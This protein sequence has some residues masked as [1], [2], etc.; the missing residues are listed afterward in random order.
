VKVH[1]FRSNPNLL[2]GETHVNVEVTKFSGTPQE[3]TERYTVILRKHNEEAE[4][5]R[6]EF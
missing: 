5:C 6:V 1:Y 3:T 4:V 2:G